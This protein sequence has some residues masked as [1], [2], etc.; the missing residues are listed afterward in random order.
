[1]SIGR[2]RQTLKI[3]VR[4]VCVREDEGG[5]LGEKRTDEAGQ[6]NERDSVHFVEKK[7][8]R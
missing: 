7:L 3:Q 5:G 4:Q 1:M 6:E 2:I 8:G